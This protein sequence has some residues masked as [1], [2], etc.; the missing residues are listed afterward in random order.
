MITA[1][2][3]L[4]LLVD[5]TEASAS[6]PAPAEPAASTAKAAPTE[7]PKICKREAT[8]E[9]RLGSKRI[10]LTKEQWNQRERADD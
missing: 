8:T 7:E 1:L 10:C 2:F 9:S 5:S 6:A 4:L 3:S